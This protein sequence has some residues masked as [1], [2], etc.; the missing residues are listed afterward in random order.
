MDERYAEIQQP[1]FSTLNNES[2]PGSVEATLTRPVRVPYL[3]E[4]AT[5]HRNE[6]ASGY[7][8]VDFSEIHR[9]EAEPRAI[10]G[11]EE[12]QRHERYEYRAVLA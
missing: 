10:K 8:L 11:V 12:A 6:S 4:K 2:P 5:G 1:K 9:E 3:C 7:A